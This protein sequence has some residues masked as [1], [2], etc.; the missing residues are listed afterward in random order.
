MPLRRAGVPKIAAAAVISGLLVG[1]LAIRA[2]AQLAARTVLRM[3]GVL[4][5]DR[6]GQGLAPAGDLNGDGFDDFLVGAAY[7]DGVFGDVGRAYV[8]I[9]GTHL[10]SLPDVVSIGRTPSGYAGLTLAG[11][12]DVNGDGYDDWLVGSPNYDTGTAPR[13]TGKVWLEFGGAA[14]DG[15]SDRTIDT[16]RPGILSVYGTSLAGVGDFNG[17]GFPDFAIGGLLGFPDSSGTYVYWGGPGL[18]NY[19]DLQLLTPPGFN[20][21]AIAA[22]DVNGDGWPDIV[23]G[24][25]GPASGRIFVYFGGPGADGVADVQIP[26]TGPFNDLFGYAISCGDFDGDGFADIL[27]GAGGRTTANGFATGEALLYRGGPTLGTAPP[28]VLDGEHVGDQLGL[29]LA[30]VGDL[31][32]DG[33][34]DVAIGAPNAD[35]PAG[36][37]AG[38]VYL[39]FGG[40][41]PDLIPD[42]VLNGEAALDL[43]GS[44][45]AA[46]GDPDLHGSPA[47]LVGAVGSDAS[48]ANAGRAYLYRVARFGI[49][50]PRAGERWNAGGP[51]TV[52]WTGA[53]PADLDLSLDDGATWQRLASG[54]G[55]AADNATTVTAPAAVSGRARLLITRAGDAPT[56]GASTLSAGLFHVSRPAAAFPAV[57][58]EPESARIGAGRLGTSLAAGFD[59]NGDGVPD[60]VAGAPARGDGAITIFDGARP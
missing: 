13:F 48:A 56:G 30:F 11:V 36:V 45:V 57:I 10:D 59:W 25:S 5:G 14:L 33:Y 35:G 41:H 51:A 20:S 7:A 52:H 21:R 19:A 40:P 8:F 23:I 50:D 6:F 9:G 24:T 46:A 32:G 16:P 53:D 27:V 60:L 37:D 12:G 17:D 54:I 29:A 42:L 2:E 47:L 22:G 18:D 4:A 44:A 26:S 15:V 39:C 31:D 34:D 49:V 55:G 28:L 43:F 3:N 1:V 38:K 58:A